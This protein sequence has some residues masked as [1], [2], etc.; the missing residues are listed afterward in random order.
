VLVDERRA[1]SQKTVV[2]RIGEVVPKTEV[3]G[4]RVE[5]KNPP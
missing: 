5:D 3:F 1:V 2:F 4:T